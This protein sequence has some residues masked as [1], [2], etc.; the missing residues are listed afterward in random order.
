MAVT[1]SAGGFGAM[2]LAILLL[3]AITLP[4]SVVGFWNAAIGFFVM[5]LERADRVTRRA[6]PPTKRSRRRRR[7]WSA[8]AMRPPE[9][10]VRNLEPLLDG[11]IAAGVAGRFQVYVLSDSDAPEVIRAEETQFV[12]LA[13]ALSDD[14]AVHY[15][16]RATN[17][18]Y[19]AGNI[20]DFCERWGDRHD[21]ALVL[22]AD[23]FMTADAVLRL[24]RRMQKDPKLGILQSLVVG[25]PSAS[26]FARIFQFG[27]RLGMRSYTPAAHGG[28]PIAGLIGATTR[29][30]AWPPSSRI[31]GCRSCRARPARRPCSVT[32]RSRRRSCAAPASRCGC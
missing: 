1:L 31:A 5:R 24:V 20:R 16:R 25:L 8:S 4:W 6:L 28:R 27:M 26:A 29:S 12:A 18:G 10:I 23:S 17:T 3:F 15:R 14:I 11:L 32:I 30:F 13:A 7:S 22:D 2:D 21:L 19:K 9:R